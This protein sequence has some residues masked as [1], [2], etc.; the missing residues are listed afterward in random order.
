MPGLLVFY[1][2][3][4]GNNRQDRVGL[5]CSVPE[6]STSVDKYAEFPSVFH[7]SLRNF[8]KAFF[9][10]FLRS[11]AVRILS[12]CYRHQTTLNGPDHVG[13]YFTE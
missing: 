2:R 5:R 8:H 10:F 3:S 6:K 9:L 1:Y 12:G 13:R 4:V 11:R 7:R